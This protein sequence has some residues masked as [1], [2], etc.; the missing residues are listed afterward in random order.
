[1]V[2]PSSPS[3]PV[4]ADESARLAALK[5]YEVL[6]TPPEES[7]DRITALA[8]RLFHAPISLVSLVDEDRHWF[9][10]V[11]G[12]N[13][14]TGNREGGF[15]TE[16]IT[17]DEV[18]IVPDATL[19]PHF[20]NH[21][22]VAGKEGL[23]FYAGAP[24]VNSEGYR[25]GALCIL[26]RTPRQF[27]ETER[28]ILH[29]L[30]ALAMD[31]L[32][33]SLGKKRLQREIAQHREAELA[34][35]QLERRFQNA[36]ELSAIGMAL[37]S[38]E[39]YWLQVNRKLCELLGYSETEL[40]EHTFQ[41][42]TYPEDLQSD[43]AYVER[44]KRGEIDSYEIEKRY[45]HRDGTLVWA[46]LSVSAV[47]D[48]A[49]R[50]LHFISQVQDI[51]DRKRA[52]S[53]LRQSEARK[54]AILDTALDCI[55]TIDHEGRIQEWN[56]AAEKTFGYPRESVLGQVLS[57]LIVPPE[58]REKHNAGLSR[59]MAT[60]DGA[61]IGKRVELPAVRADGERITVEL[62][63]VPI[64]FA[65]PPVFTGHLRDISE[66]NR[67]DERLRL[68]ESVAVHANDAILITEAEP[69]DLPGPRILYANEAF[70]RT[71]GYS[72]EEIIGQTPRILQG[73]GTSREALEKIRAALK[74]WQPVVVELL[75]YT[76]D[77]SPF[78][79]ELSI[80]PV[81]NESGWF[82][83]WVSIQRD[84]TERKRITDALHTSESRYQHIAANVPGM[85][86]QFVMRPDGSVSFPYV[87]E[88]CREIFGLEP[89]SIMDDAMTLVDRMHPD[90]AEN[91]RQSVVASAQNLEPW[92]WEGR[93]QMPTGRVVWVRASSRPKR[94]ED[95]S[96][97]WDGLL[98]DATQNKREK[99]ALQAAKLEAEIAREEAERA[100]IAKSEFLSRMSHELRTPLNAILGFG[101]LLELS[102][103]SAEDVQSTQQ[104][105]KAGR[106]LLDLI[107]EVLDIARIE[108]GHLALSPE[109][110]HVSEVVLEA[111]DLVRPLAAARD[112]RIDEG[113]IRSCTVNVR[114]DRQRL[115]QVLLNLLSNAVKYNRQG[116]RVTLDCQTPSAEAVPVSGQK[117]RLS[118]QDSGAG[119]DPD[120]RSR[121]FTPFDRLGAEN[122]GIEGT[123]MGLS[124]SR[125]LA[126]AMA[127][128]LDFESEVGQGSTFW[129]ELPRAADSVS[130]AEPLPLAAPVNEFVSTKLVALYI[131]DNPSNLQLVQRLLAHRPEIRLLTAMQGGLGYELARQHRPDLILLDMN[132]P[133]QGGQ[134]VLRHLRE[135]EK[136]AAIPVIVVSAD[137]TEGQIERMLQ[138]G[139]QKYLTKPFDVREFLSILDDHIRQNDLT[140]V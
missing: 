93:F 120:L 11:Y 64:P 70:M 63:V 116:G 16:V 35:T 138:A 3:E 50:L 140:P 67:H 134:E 22:L 1:M 48:E 126:Q 118:V 44:V 17:S 21:P 6:D 41:E 95:G 78:W 131:E 79:V 37:V 26:D 96:T 130:R 51:S 98:F 24:L 4:P 85:V 136:T 109:A 45:L 36:F 57:E 90:D 23:R 88:G 86:Y 137:A 62:A 12:L 107:N 74:S 99:E 83:H 8:A 18:F 2:A 69:I 42:L 60:G 19:D 75:N 39:G 110:V 133:D 119:I 127:G 54:A 102:P 27:T 104:I 53:A 29:D 61:I 73:E 33:L 5:A 122:S 113:S 114:A 100:N 128:E 125:H 7:Y 9:K 46:M 47:R 121:L 28:A 20:K 76:R 97:T 92:E 106:H 132:L 10:S 123:G 55:I 72:A 25:L 14:K 87:S 56:P 111:L 40:L 139:A 129:I 135:D 52:E 43:M 82:T 65:D 13:A 103:L 77:G 94:E 101:Q 84:I 58:L 115:K 105:V 124:L 15:C 89:Q 66:R 68:L 108:S 71:T 31:E 59:Y 32:E 38:P 91:F 34:L 80:V 49:G 81:A 30:A 117:V 112:I